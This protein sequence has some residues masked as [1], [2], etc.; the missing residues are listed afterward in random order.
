MPASPPDDIIDIEPIRT[1]S[2]AADAAPPPR[3]DASFLLSHP[4]H[5]IALGGGSGLSPMAPGTVGTL[6]A[7]ASFLVLSHWLDASAWGWTLLG[8]LVVGWWACTVTAR[9]ARSADPGFIVWDEVLAFWLV[10]WLLTPA[11][12]WAQLAAFGLFRYFDAAKPGPVRWADQVFKGGGWR[13]GF[14]II[15]DDLVAALCTL[16]VISLWVAL[17]RAWA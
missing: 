1:V 12:G 4:A 16:L 9:H 14:G 8:G 6:W 10:L 11:S 2:N 15:F 3:V 7:W 13:G 17:Q 5:L